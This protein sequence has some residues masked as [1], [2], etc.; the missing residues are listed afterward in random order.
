[1]SRNSL[2]ASLALRFYENRYLLVLSLLTILMAGY[3]ALSNMPRIED[4]RIT[5]RYPR[6]VTFLPG[7]SAERVSEPLPDSFF[8]K[9]ATG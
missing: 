4:P 3:A 5:N 9:K 8:Q 7:A 6:V 1:M 2:V